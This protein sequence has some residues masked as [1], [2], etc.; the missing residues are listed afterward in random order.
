MLEV[1]KNDYPKKRKN[2]NQICAGKFCSSPPL[3]QFTKYNSIHRA[4]PPVFETSSYPNE[5]LLYSCILQLITLE[6]A[7]QMPS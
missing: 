3:I 7:A 2:T 5:K 1:I 6:T 4:D